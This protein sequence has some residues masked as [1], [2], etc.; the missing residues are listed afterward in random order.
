MKYSVRAKR[1][2]Q[3]TAKVFK[4]VMDEEG[5]GRSGSGSADGRSRQIR[6]QVWRKG[7]RLR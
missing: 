6:K 7:E 2:Q 3:R 4:A 5:G 1:V